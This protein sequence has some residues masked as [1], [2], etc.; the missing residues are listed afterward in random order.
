MMS[1][2]PATKMCGSCG[3]TATADS[4]EGKAIKVYRRTLGSRLLCCNKCQLKFTYHYIGLESSGGIWAG[5]RR[6]QSAALNIDSRVLT[7]SDGGTCS[8]AAPCST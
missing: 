6:I 3:A 8:R 2:T 4:K 7:L 5:S 1:A